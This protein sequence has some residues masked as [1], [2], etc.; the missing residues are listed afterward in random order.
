MRF[1]GRSTFSGRTFRVAV[2]SRRLLAHGLTVVVSASR[3][4]GTARCRS[5]TTIACAGNRA[6][7]RD[8]ERTRG[9]RGSAVGDASAASVGCP[10]HLYLLAN[11][12][13][14]VGAVAHQVINR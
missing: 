1:W 9:I 14:H 3:V 4:A 2:G 5:P 8:L 11:Q 10:G 7:I 13:L 6:D 12:R